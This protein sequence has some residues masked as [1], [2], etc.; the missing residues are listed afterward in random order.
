V[1]A[2][3]GDVQDQKWPSQISEKHTKTMAHLTSL[4]EKRLA[5]LIHGSEIRYLLLAELGAP[6]H[7]PNFL[8]LP[9]Q[10]AGKFTGN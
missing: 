9:A 2:K 10:M 7:S 1:L 6:R 3:G 8:F 5:A 4:I